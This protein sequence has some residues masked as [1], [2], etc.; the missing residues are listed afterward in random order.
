MSQLTDLFEAVKESN[1]TKTQLEDYHTQLTKLFADM[2]LAAADLEKAEAIFYNEKPEKTDIATKRKWAVTEQGQRQI[3][4]KHSLKATE[5]ML[6]SVKNR[7]Y[8]QY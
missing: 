4:I 5:K 1:L 6:G 8:S 2:H 3:Q 7:I